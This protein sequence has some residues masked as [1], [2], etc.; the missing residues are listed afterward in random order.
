MRYFIF[1]IISPQ[2]YRVNETLQSFLATYADK[3]KT[4]RQ[5]SQSQHYLDAAFKGIQFLKDAVQNLKKPFVCLVYLRVLPCKIADVFREQQSVSGFVYFSALNTR[6][7]VWNMVGIAEST[8]FN[9]RSPVVVFRVIV[10]IGQVFGGVFFESQRVI[11]FIKIRQNYTLPLLNLVIE[12]TF[13][14]T[15]HKFGKL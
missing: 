8:S 13:H 9:T 1:L 5:G 3:K 2:E 10:K 14:Y 15:G 12:V 6:S 7:F 11:H 4:P